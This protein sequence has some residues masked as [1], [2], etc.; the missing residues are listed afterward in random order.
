[1]G[2]WVVT[3]HRSDW[4]NAIFGSW[5]SF[6]VRRVRTPSVG[7]CAHT[8]VC[9]STDRK[10][11][12][13]P[14]SA[15]VFAGRGRVHQSGN[16]RRPLPSR[17]S[18]RRARAVWWR[19]RRRCPTFASHPDHGGGGYKRR[20]RT[21]VPGGLRRGP[22]G[23]RRERCPEGLCTSGTGGGPCPVCGHLCPF[24]TLQARGVLRLRTPTSPV[25]G[26]RHRWSGV[27]RAG[28]VR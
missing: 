13:G 17:R 25:S 12:A 2:P 1:M 21:T 28:P 19:G 4:T 24:L 16:R 5:V 3:G 26:R 20:L 23:L 18:A 6:P 9:R 8:C 7:T 11:R 27:S 15:Q 22:R 14:T 10:S